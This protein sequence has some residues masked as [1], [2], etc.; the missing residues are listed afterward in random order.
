MSVAR[1]QPECKWRWRVAQPDCKTTNFVGCTLHLANAAGVGTTP[2][3]I[4]LLKQKETKNS[5]FIK[6]EIN[7]IKGILILLIII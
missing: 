7:I 2:K 1:E 3:F 4:Q 5:V 6:F